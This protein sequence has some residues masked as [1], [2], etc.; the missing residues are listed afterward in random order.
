MKE[1]ETTRASVQRSRPCQVHRDRVDAAGQ[2]IVLADVTAR[3]WKVEVIASKREYRRHPEP[4]RV[5]GRLCRRTG[6]S[7][8][9]SSPPATSGGVPSISSE[10]PARGSIRRLA[11]SV[12]S[13]L[14]GRHL[15][16]VAAALAVLLALPALGAEWILDDYYHRTI[17]L[18]RSRL[19]DLL[20]T[21]SEMFRFFRGG[22]GPANSSTLGS[23]PGGPT[24]ISRPSSCNP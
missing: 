18:G 2:G 5:P 23:S 4:G 10:E 22:L 14:K 12:G 3:S 13:L 20:G 16:V 17:L 21:P 15:P 8:I 19:R 11:A 9:T 1:S 6:A 24:R 7:S